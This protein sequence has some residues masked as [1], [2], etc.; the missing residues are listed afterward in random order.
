MIQTLLT[1]YM[2]TVDGTRIWHVSLRFLEHCFWNLDIQIR[3]RN[4]GVCDE[5]MIKFQVIWPVTYTLPETAHSAC[6]SQH[7]SIN[8]ISNH[9]IQTISEFEVIFKEL[10]LQNSSPGH[11]IPDIPYGSPALAEVIPGCRGN[12]QVSGSKMK[13]SPPPK[14]KPAVNIEQNE[15]QQ[16]QTWGQKGTDS[17]HPRVGYFIYH[18]G[19]E[20]PG[21]V[22]ITFPLFI[23]ENDPQH[24]L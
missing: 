23:C 7:I 12:T 6:L 3:N 18:A 9:F 21:Y 8:V 20:M 15:A 4:G 17:T 13:H 14:Q 1:Y 19:S 2:T 10:I 5:R 11:L 22:T 16:V 24:L